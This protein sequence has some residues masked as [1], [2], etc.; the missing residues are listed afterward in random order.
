MKEKCN[1]ADLGNRYLYEQTFPELKMKGRRHISIFLGSLPQSSNCL[2]HSLIKELAF[3]EEGKEQ[4]LDCR[5]Q[6]RVMKDFTY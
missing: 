2:P 5:V 4:S 3:W 1:S 6:I